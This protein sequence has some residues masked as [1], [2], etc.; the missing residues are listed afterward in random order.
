MKKINIVVFILALLL[1]AALGYIIIDKYRAAQQRQQLS[2]F[3]QG[4]QVGYQQAILQ[5]IQQVETCQQ[6]PVTF[7]NKTINVISVDCLGT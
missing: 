5:L 6:V 7:Q 1:I 4:I 3:Q 2:V